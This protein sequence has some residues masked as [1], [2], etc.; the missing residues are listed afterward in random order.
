M[1]V[2]C[3]RVYHNRVLFY[4]SSVFIVAGTVNVSVLMQSADCN[5]LSSSRIVRA[6]RSE[7]PHW[8]EPSSSVNFVAMRIDS[9]AD[10]I[11]YMV[12][13]PAI[14]SGYIERGGLLVARTLQHVA[15]GD[16]AHCAIA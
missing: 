14:K 11:S 2:S 10:S 1:R 13:F 3:A 5:S 15:D 12:T 7:R 16:V 4:G 6:T 9:I 8:T